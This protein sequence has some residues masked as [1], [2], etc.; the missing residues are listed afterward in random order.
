MEPPPNSR[1]DGKYKISVDLQGLLPTLAI[2]GK[3]I[4]QISP[5]VSKGKQLWI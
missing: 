2:G 5:V 1:K 4:I 3:E